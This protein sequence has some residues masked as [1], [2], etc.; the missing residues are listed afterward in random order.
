[1][2]GTWRYPKDRFMAAWLFHSC[3]RKCSHVPAERNNCE[4][5]VRSSGVVCFAAYGHRGNRRQ[6][7]AHVCAVLAV[8]VLDQFSAQRLRVDSSRYGALYGSGSNCDCCISYCRLVAKG[9]G[10]HRICRG[11]YCCASRNRPPPAIHRSRNA[12]RPD[13]RGHQ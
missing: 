7:P 4:R 13:S 5:G 2:A 11:A 6:L 8:C 9:R 12:R 10:D 1:M 3:F